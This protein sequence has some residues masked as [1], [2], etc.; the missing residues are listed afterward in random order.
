M[1]RSFSTS[2]NFNE[3][4]ALDFV[5]I[6]NLTGG[7]NIGTA[8][9]TVDQYQGAF[10]NQTTASQAINLPQPTGATPFPG[11]IAKSFTVVNTGTVTFTMNGLS[12]YVGQAITFIFSG[13]EIPNQGLV[14]SAVSGTSI[15][16]TT[17]TTTTS[18]TTTTT[19]TTS[20]TT[21]TTTVF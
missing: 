21:T 12:V 20:T 7:G 8:A 6:G 18:T 9:A 15:T 17:S 3:Q 10:V 16:T 19:S 11:G 1:V 4:N 13:I 2:P 14:W 5:T